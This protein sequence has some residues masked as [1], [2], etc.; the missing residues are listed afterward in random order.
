MLIWV[1]SVVA[2]VGDGDVVTRAEGVG[3][4]PARM[5]RA[6]KGVSSQGRL[7]ARRAAEIVAV[8][9]L[10]RGV[11]SA[12]RRVGKGRVRNG[13]TSWRGRVSGYQVGETR[14][15]KDG[16]VRVIVTRKSPRPVVFRR[17]I[18]WRSKR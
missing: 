16:S 4:P 2:M 1:F 17:T 11:A 12:D 8:R 13:H 9:N 10:G 7:M 3:K 18:V 5:V 15:Q 6:Q 14:W